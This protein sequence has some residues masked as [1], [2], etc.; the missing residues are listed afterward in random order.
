LA[1]T[2]AL[3]FGGL[4]GVRDLGSIESAIARPYCG[5]YRAISDKVAALVQSLA[6]NH[7][8]ID[9]NKRTALYMM[10]LLLQRS[11]YRLRPQGSDIYN[12]EVEAMISA[13]VEHQID[14]AGLSRWFKERIIRLG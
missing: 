4:D 9:G 5:Y 8:F 13:V 7:G 1:H 10:E 3:Q 6:L 14:L 11:G 2:L 12:E